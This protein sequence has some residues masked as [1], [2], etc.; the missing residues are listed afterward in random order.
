M[1]A[2]VALGLPASNANGQPGAG[3]QSLGHPALYA[4]LHKSHYPPMNRMQYY[5]GQIDGLRRHCLNQ[6][7]PAHA[8]V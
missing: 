6:S 3:R 4:T 1:H 2:V 7:A 8:Y 5:C